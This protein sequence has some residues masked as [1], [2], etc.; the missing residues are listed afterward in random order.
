MSYD[1]VAQHLVPATDLGDELRPRRTG[2]VETQY[3]PASDQPSHPGP[4]S[5]HPAAEQQG[6]RPAA[7]VTRAVPRKDQTPHRDGTRLSHEAGLTNDRTSAFRARTAGRIT[8]RSALR[9]R[10]LAR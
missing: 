10:R 6:G 8:D 5:P 1:V 3:H 2:P 7:R 4:H 9:R